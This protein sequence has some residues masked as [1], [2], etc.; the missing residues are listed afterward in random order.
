MTGSDRPTYPGLERAAVEIAL[1]SGGINR[2]RSERRMRK[3]FRSWARQQPGEILEPIDKWLSALSDED[4]YIVCC[5]GK[6]ETEQEALL[7]EAPPFTDDTLDRYFNE[8][9]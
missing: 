4:L 8:V 6:G 7:A 9:C 3:E 1:D 5:G 2:G